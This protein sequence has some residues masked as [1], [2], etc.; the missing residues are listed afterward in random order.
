MREKGKLFIALK[1]LKLRDLKESPDGFYFNKNDSEYEIVK[2]T[3]Q[4]VVE[5]EVTSSVEDID[6]D[7]DEVDPFYDIWEDE[8]EYTTTHW[9]ADMEDEGSDLY[10]D[11]ESDY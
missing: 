9:A 11:E 8:A 5:E 7:F 3:I 6:A 10:A 2:R 1:N 4:E